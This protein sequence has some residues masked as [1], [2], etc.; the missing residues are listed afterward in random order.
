MRF[1]DGDQVFVRR[2]DGASFTSN[3]INV[4]VESGFYD[5][6]VGGGGKS[7][8]VEEI[9]ADVE[10]ATANVFRAID[11]SMEAP[12]PGSSDRD[13]LAAY[14]ALQMMRT[15]E[16]RERTLFPERLARYLDGRELTRELVASYLSEHHLGFP[17]SENEVKA[18]SDFAYIALQDASV[19]T[20]EFS[21]RITLSSLT[22]FAPR[23]AQLHWCVEHDRKQRLL[24]SDTPL[25]LWRKPSFRDAFEGF[26]VEDAEE[27][28]FPLDPAKQLVL[29]RTRRSPSVRITPQRSATCN[30]DAAFAC[31]NFVIARPTEMTRA[32]QLELPV[33]RP[34]LRFNT[35]PLRRR[36][37]GGRS[38]GDGDVLHMWVP[39]R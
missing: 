9:F 15:P 34:T 2:R 14:L 36:L 3:C 21:M 30:Q 13:V 31:H 6:D 37:P 22:E 10:G 38:V 18:A 35:G 29:S 23:L 39:R 8:A 16:Q 17:P 7:K 20:P 4:A 28:R 32:M 1:A 11:E 33:K 24:T 19:F 12:A 26:G 5:I 27:I 25:V